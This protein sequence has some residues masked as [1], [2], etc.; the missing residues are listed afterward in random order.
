MGLYLE[1][2]IKRGTTVQVIGAINDRKY[3]SYVAHMNEYGKVV[4]ILADDH[5]LVVFRSGGKAIKMNKRAL[6]GLDIPFIDKPKMFSMMKKGPMKVDKKS[7]SF[8]TFS[9][10][11]RV[12]NTKEL[13]DLLSDGWVILTELDI[14]KFNEMVEKLKE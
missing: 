11:I 4:S 6:I 13:L 2:Q 9:N 12:Y 1:C 7:I 10:I 8:D 14:D 5:V 3:H